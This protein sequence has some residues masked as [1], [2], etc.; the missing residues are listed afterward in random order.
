MTDWEKLYQQNEKVWSER[1]DTLLAEMLPEIPACKEAMAL[2]S[3]Y[4][5]S[6]MTTCRLMGIIVHKSM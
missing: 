3:R 1:P 6:A 2:W 5:I 4:A